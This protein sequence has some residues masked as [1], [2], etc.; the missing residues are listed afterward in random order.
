M[1]EMQKEVTEFALKVLA[2]PL[3][4]WFSDRL[5]ERRTSLVLLEIPRPIAPP[6]KL[7]KHPRKKPTRP[8]PPLPERRGRFCPECGKERR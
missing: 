7:K 5:R 4:C 8:K 6:Q 3:Y 1:D 2:K